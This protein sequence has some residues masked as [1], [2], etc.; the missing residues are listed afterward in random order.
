M[1]Q[2][3]SACSN[4]NRNIPLKT[5]TSLQWQIQGFPGGG[6]GT[7]PAWNR[8]KNW[9]LWGMGEG[10]PPGSDTARRGWYNFQYGRQSQFRWRN[11]KN[12][13]F[14]IMAPLYCSRISGPHCNCIDIPTV[15]VGGPSFHNIKWDLM[16][17]KIKGVYGRIF[18]SFCGLVNKE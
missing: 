6:G 11:E 2:I 4:S 1:S 8:E 3:S 16:I 18:F 15:N 17:P 10:N 5:G 9:S 13:K 14:V 7:N 12:N